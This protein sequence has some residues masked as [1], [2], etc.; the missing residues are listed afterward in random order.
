MCLDENHLIER[1]RLKTGSRS[2]RGWL[3]TDEP[4]N[5]HAP[6]LPLIGD[7]EFRSVQETSRSLDKPVAAFLPIRG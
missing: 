6:V 5:T 3:L 2:T 1:A 7:I 4:T